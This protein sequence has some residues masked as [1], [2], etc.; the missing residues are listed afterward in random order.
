MIQ[1]CAKITPSVVFCRDWRRSD[2]CI[3]ACDRAKMP[4]RW[5]QHQSGCVMA[6][7]FIGFATPVWLHDQEALSCQIGY[8]DMTLRDYSAIAGFEP[9]V[10]GSTDC[11]FYIQEVDQSTAQVTEYWSG[12]GTKLF[13]DRGNRALV[14]QVAMHMLTCL[15]NRHRKS[16]IYISTHDS[17]LPEAGLQKYRS[18]VSAFRSAGYDIQTTDPQFGIRV[19][20]AYLP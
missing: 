10:G 4:K 7:V 19:W 18:I 8:D 16:E 2:G 11:H 9:R 12:I 15:L 5:L 20:R 6:F 3:H 17:Y 13:L 14:L 1:D